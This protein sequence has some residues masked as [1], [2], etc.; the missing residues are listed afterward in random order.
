MARKES[1][2][3]PKHAADRLIEV[4][5]RNGTLDKILKSGIGEQIQD[6]IDPPSPPPPPPTLAVPTGTYIKLDVPFGDASDGH[7]YSWALS[8]DGTKVVI[9]SFAQLTAEETDD[10]LYDVYLWDAVTGTIT[11]LTK[12]YGNDGHAWSDAISADG[13]KVVI[14]TRVQLTPEDDNGFDDVYLWDTA[15]G[16]NTL[17]TRAVGTLGPSY[18]WVMSADGS[19]VVIDSYAQLTDDDENAFQDVYL[20]DAATGENRL[21]TKAHG[22]E[23]YSSGN[24][25][26]ADGTKVLIT[27]QAQL[28]AEDDNHFQDVYLWDAATGENK[29]LTK[30]VGSPGYSYSWLMSDDGSKVLIDSHAQLTA[31]DQ[32]AFGDVY[33]WDAITGENRLLTRAV[34]NEGRSS[35]EAISSDGT[36]VLIASVAQLTAED[37]NGF[38]DLY[39]WDALT[40]ENT[41][42]TQAVGAEGHSFAIAMS[43]DGSKVLLN[44]RAQLTADDTMNRT[45]AYLWCADEGL[46][47][48]PFDVDIKSGAWGKFSDDGSSFVLNVENDVYWYMF[49]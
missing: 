49:G 11:L 36:K 34:G 20:W 32:N 43:A 40:G 28:T 3:P 19:K 5:E 44:S 47:L 8:A 18:S 26:S 23:G 9:N 48:L 16:E 24:A 17:L 37:E 35:A 31:E 1:A 13:S 6:E 39:L 27:S 14:T 45:N 30:A 33:L 21:L 2:G 7:A 46:S 12:P 29:L 22:Y 4:H 41:L 10:T 38:Q 15:T 25:I 42:L